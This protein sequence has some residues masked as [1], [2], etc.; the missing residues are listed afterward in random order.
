MNN[1][2]AKQLRRLSHFNVKSWRKLD[3]GDKYSV[4]IHQK[5]PTLIGTLF[6]RGQRTVYKLLKKGLT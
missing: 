1:K 5:E 2:R 6:C 4:E 3:N